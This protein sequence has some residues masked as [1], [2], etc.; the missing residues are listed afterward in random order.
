MVHLLH[1]LPRE[2]EGEDA[3]PTAKSEIQ[4]LPYLWRAD[5]P[6]PINSLSQRHSITTFLK[7]GSGSHVAGSQQLEVRILLSGAGE[8]IFDP[9]RISKYL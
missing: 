2:S 9:I 7:E 4:S 5:Q 1:L 3:R 6:T 8:C